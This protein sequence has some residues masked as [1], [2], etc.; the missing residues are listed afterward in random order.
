MTCS[1]RTPTSLKCTS[2]SYMGQDGLETGLPHDFDDLLANQL[3]RPVAEH[4]RVSFA[5][6]N[7]AQIGTATCEQKRRIRQNRLS[8]ITQRHGGVHHRVFPLRQCSWESHGSSAVVTGGSAIVFW[9]TVV[10]QRRRMT[11]SAIWSGGADA[12]IVRESS[13]GSGSSS[14]SI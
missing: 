10:A 12:S 9:T 13:L 14:V 2:V 5:H 11:S 7:I 6:E 1:K 3:F 8:V 4:L